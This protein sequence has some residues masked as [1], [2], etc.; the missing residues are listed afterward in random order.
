MGMQ[1]GSPQINTKVHHIMEAAGLD[2]PTQHTSSM[3]RVSL[4]Y[5]IKREAVVCG[6]FTGKTSRLKAKSS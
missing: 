4:V 2:I 3:K 5:E 6:L 1:F